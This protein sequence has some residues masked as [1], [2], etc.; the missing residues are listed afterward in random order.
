[1][2]FIIFCESSV[3]SGDKQPNLVSKETLPTAAKKQ[4]K[5]KKKTNENVNTNEILA[6]REPIPYQ[7]KKNTHTHTH[8]KTYIP[9]PTYKVHAGNLRVIRHFHHAFRVS[10]QGKKQKQ[11]CQ[12]KT[13]WLTC[14]MSEREKERER[15]LDTY[16]CINSV[17]ISLRGGIYFLAVCGCNRICCTS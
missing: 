15:E 14:M 5:T 9:T 7:K 3:P 4:Q 12:I 6:W 1:M 16:L 11:K 17:A 10:L 2:L 13:W 8:T